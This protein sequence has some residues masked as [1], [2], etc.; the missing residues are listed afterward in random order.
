MCPEPVEDDY[1]LC[2]NKEVYVQVEVRWKARVVVNA[3]PF[4]ERPA[5][6]HC[7]KRRKRVSPGRALHFNSVSAVIR[8]MKFLISE[9]YE[10]PQA[11]E[12]VLALTAP[13]QPS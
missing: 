2:E 11:N 5:V 6:D 13:C 1:R 3:H 8:K 7:R 10:R 9:D 12:G 4:A